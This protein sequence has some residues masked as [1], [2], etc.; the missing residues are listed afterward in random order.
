MLN[1]WDGKFFGVEIDRRACDFAK[2]RYDLD[3]FCGTL[4]DYQFKANQFD[5]ITYW[6][7]FEHVVSPSDE[8]KH[9]RKA[10]KKGGKLIIGQLPNWESLDR[11]LFKGNNYHNCVPCHT[12]FFSERTIKNYLRRYGFKEIKLGY[13]TWIPT[14]ISWNLIMTLNRF[15]NNTIFPNKIVCLILSIPLLPLYI[16]LKLIK[17]SLTFTIECRK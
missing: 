5:L 11:V 3:L 8:L 12:F 4:Q 13:E 14:Q 1:R 7:S 17:R 10:L 2:K 6:Q 16:L 9:V 15:F